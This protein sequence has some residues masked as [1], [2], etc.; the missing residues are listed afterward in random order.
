[1]PLYSHN[2]LRDLQPTEADC[3]A[4]GGPIT[5]VEQEEMALILSE[6]KADAAKS[7]VTMSTSMVTVEYCAFLEKY[8][9]K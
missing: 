6:A 1:M 4:Q 8:G 2:F 9:G 5:Q 3:V 7:G